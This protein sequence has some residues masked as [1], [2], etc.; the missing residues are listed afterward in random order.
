M[1]A[2]KAKKTI[3]KK[4]VKKS[5]KMKCCP[6]KTLVLIGA[7]VAILGSFLWGRYLPLIGGILVL[8]GEFSK[9]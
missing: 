9:K 1:A 3:A 8:L 4:P 2:K 6:G 7:V 5:K